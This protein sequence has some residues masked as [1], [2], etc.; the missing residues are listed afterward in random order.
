MTFKITKQKS[1]GI[2]CQASREAFLFLFI[3]FQKHRVKFLKLAENGNT[4]V[5]ETINYQVF[6]LLIISFL[7]LLNLKSKVSLPFFR[8]HFRYLFQAIIPFCHHFFV[9][10]FYIEC[11][12]YVICS[13][14]WRCLHYQTC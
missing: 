10:L 1:A 9:F 5:S 4:P 14:I 6:F 12:A 11:A 8:I 7:F 13:N 2:N 3:F